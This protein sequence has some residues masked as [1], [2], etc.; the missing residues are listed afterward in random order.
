M[1]TQAE[2]RDHIAVKLRSKKRKDLVWSDV[3]TAFGNATQGEKDDVVGA[4]NTAD[5]RRLARA[6]ATVINKHIN[7]QAITEANAIVADNS[8]SFDELNDVYGPIP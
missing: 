5:T 3:T 2:V 6:I 4:I 8:I 1:P 7:A